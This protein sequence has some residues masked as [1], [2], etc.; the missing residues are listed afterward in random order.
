MPGPLKKGERHRCPIEEC[1]CVIEV[2]EKCK[3][4]PAEK[5]Q[6][7]KCCCGCEMEKE[8]AKEPI[9]EEYP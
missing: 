7:P 9:G 6:S 1:G 4:C 8:K 5:A 2:V 3:Q